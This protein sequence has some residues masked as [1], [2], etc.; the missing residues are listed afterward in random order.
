MSIMH[1]TETFLWEQ[2]H[3]GGWQWFSWFS[4]FLSMHDTTLGNTKQQKSVNQKKKKKTYQ[5]NKD[6]EN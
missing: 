2:F 6:Q 1:L 5:T 3:E 4:T